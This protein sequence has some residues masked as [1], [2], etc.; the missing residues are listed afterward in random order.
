MSDAELARARRKILSSFVFSRESVHSLADAISVP[1]TYPGGEDVVKFFQNYLD[2]G[3]E[4]HKGRRSARRE[5]VS[6]TQRRRD[7]VEHSEGGNQTGRRRTS[8][9]RGFA[10]ARLG[11][12]P[13]LAKRN[14]A[15]KGRAQRLLTHGC[16]ER[17]VAQRPDG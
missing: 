2:S 15:K 12:T 5:E 3:G 11:A 10:Q 4:D 8:E 13:S 17:R 1:S 6:G 9:G 16:E 14:H 7:R